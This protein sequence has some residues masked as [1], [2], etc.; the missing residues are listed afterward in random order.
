MGYALLEEMRRKGVPPDPITFTSLFTISGQA[1]EGER[2]LLLYRV[3]HFTLQKGCSPFRL[4]TYDGLL[5]KL[6][7]RTCCKYHFAEEPK[8]AVLTSKKKDEKKVNVS[9]ETCTY[10]YGSE[11]TT[12]WLHTDITPPPCLIHTMAS[13]Q[14][15]HPDPQYWA[16]STSRVRLA[17]FYHVLQ[18]SFT[19]A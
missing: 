16:C 13:A 9:K 11:Y 5:G 10:E 14:Q 8:V 17:C 2:P 4:T 7:G 15:P 12:I 18:T 19:H 1:K 6:E 3:T